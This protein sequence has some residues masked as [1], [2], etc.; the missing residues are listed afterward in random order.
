MSKRL[1]KSAL[2]SSGLLFNHIA[3]AQSVESETG[4]WVPAGTFALSNIQNNPERE[5]SY[6]G[7]SLEKS[8]LATYLPGMTIIYQVK[9]DSTQDKSSYVEGRTQSG[10][11]VRVLKSEISSGKFADRSVRDVVVHREHEACRDLACDGDKILVGVG[12]SFSIAYEDDE[13]ID[14]QNTDEFAISYSKHK[15]E[16][17]ERKGFLTRI[18]DRPFPSWSVI[19]GYASALSVGCGEEIG[20]GTEF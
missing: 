5:K 4:H 1:I 10:L 20:K 8:R 14:L 6:L 17:M 3:C 11:P 13:R 19:D 2:L 7:A 16:E 18:K 15:F 9:T 12:Y